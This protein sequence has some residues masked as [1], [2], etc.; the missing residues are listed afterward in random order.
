MG[1]RR[2]TLAALVSLCALVGCLFVGSV[3]AQ[4][5]VVHEY[6]S[7]ITEVPAEGPHKEAVAVHGPL[8]HVDAMAVNSGHLW[9]MEREAGPAR[10]D[11]FDAASGG[12]EFQLGWPTSLVEPSGVAV[13]HATG[14][15]EL[16]VPFEDE[17]APH[18]R[19]PVVAVFGPSGNIQARWTGA[20]APVAFHYEVDSVAVDNSQSLSDWAAGDVYVATRSNNQGGE[21]VVDV[22]MPEGGGKEKYVGR[23]P[24]PEP[25]GLFPND[26]ERYLAVDEANGDVLVAEGEGT[27]EAV[28]DVFEPSPVVGQYTLVRKLTGAGSPTGSFRQIDGVAV[29]SS[30]GYVYVIDGGAGG[31]VVDQFSAEGV[32]LGHLTGTPSG[33]FAESQSVAVDPASHDV[34]V[35]DYHFDRKAGFVDVF[36]PTVVVPDV[37]SE[38]ASSVK[39]RS[40]TLN[41]LVN[42]VEAGAATCHFVWGTSAAFGSEA[43]CEP[44]GVANG[45]SPQP[46]HAALG[47]LSPD[48]TY[49]YRLQAS[50]ASGTN[51]G[52][53]SQDQEFT[54][55]GPGILEQSASIVTSDSATLGAKV[56][57][58]DASTTCYFQYGTSVAYGTS[59]PVPPGFALG[60]GKGGVAVSVHLQGLAAGTTYHYRVVAFSEPGGE[61]VTVEGPDETFT[62]Q[63]VSSAIALPDG[64]AWEMVSPPNKQGSGIF[65]LGYEQG[66]DIQA[67]ADGSGITYGADSPFVV[68]PAGSRSLEVTQVISNRVVP[69]SWATAD[70]TTAHDEGPSLPAVG[71]SAEYKLFSS[72]LSLGLVAPA[73]RTPLPPLP[74]GSEKTIYFREANG[75]YKALVTSGNVPPGTKFGG[76]GEVA[77]AFAFVSASPD[78]SHVV[79]NSQVALEAGAPAAGGLYEWAGGKLQLVS[80]LP[81][82]ERTSQG[83]LGDHGD[84]ITGVVRHAISD[85]GSRVV[86][87]GAGGLYLRD[88][89]RG[90]TVQVDA[91]EEGLPETSGTSHYRTA[92]RDDSR[93]FFT[94]GRRLTA[95]S[96]SD[97]E[98]ED[99]YVFEVTSGAGEPLAGKVRDLTAMDGGEDASVQGV[100]G[101]SED[102]SYVYFVA[103]GLLG[104][105][106]AHGAE[107]GH[108]LYVA[109]YEAGAG[110]W[111]APKF[112]AALSAGD[113]PTW[114]YG[115]ET[116]L[117]RMTARVAPDGRYLAFMSER[118]LTG[119]EN[120]DVNSDVP[121]EEV[122]LYDAGSG[123]VVCASCNPSGGRPL[124]LRVNSGFDERLVDYTPD[125]WTGRWL[126]GNIP[127]WTTSALTK[128]L[129]QSRY[130]SDSG[131]LF[132]DSADA[133][134][135]ADVN[136]KEDV[137]EYEP[138]GVGSCQGPGHGQSASAVFDEGIGGC[139][140]LISAG[141][142]SEESAFM[143]AS[144]TGGDV[145][146]LTLSR[147][148]PQDYDTSIDL[149]DA[150]EC[151]TAAPCAP[152]AA[153]T[154]PPCATGDACKPAPTPQPTLFGA[155]SSETFSG[156]GN[157]VPSGSQPAVTARSAGQAQKLA[158]ALKACR[159]ESRR[160]R[161]EC[162]RQARKRYGAK[163]ARAGK[164]VS[165]RTRR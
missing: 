44:A 72:D 122:F 143:D 76:N 42:P 144:E 41:G 114:G 22:F 158:R 26:F 32:Y 99:R 39:A 13:G 157:V 119:Y 117:E 135:P 164:S 21:S 95:G 68:N 89:A 45:N 11:E 87:E 18:V 61:P 116:D 80:V 137:Y 110:A 98:L 118:S 34:Y 104:D 106:R 38:P 153:L 92:S 163:H 6:L 133:L 54:T 159:K 24:G 55:S 132:F 5:A 162:K 111:S 129:Y 28:I 107:G 156:A 142:S 48:T 56:D 160:R 128:A 19:E 151:T 97:S 33:P 93:V 136:G 60:A 50:N 81:D 103:G 86:W 75:A 94:S 154:P 149:Y 70:I 49:H 58:N 9:T 130:L 101:A 65:A 29:D 147:L 66:D 52:E 78:L 146:F 140:A 1:A 15:A 23:L 125:L 109:H 141:T 105:A 123:R 138:E 145:F 37:V 83:V 165:A 77:G 91:A 120:R 17:V 16:Y 90:E 134:V 59:L 57:P 74:A 127:G 102:G 148:A 4:A 150:H 139:I 69:G 131:R 79:V 2:L 40:A 12:F 85:D 7:Q 3:A 64:R 8:R 73:G 30:E 53:P 113:G 71:Q 82:K 14:E 25:G 100:I 43:P 27:P 88:V 152:E 47:G 124:G 112:I 115:D 62:T 96:T 84:E 63:A 35:G 67:A 51:P 161:A 108:Y 10:V 155:P 31:A 36:A 121:D 46:V 126:S 20:D